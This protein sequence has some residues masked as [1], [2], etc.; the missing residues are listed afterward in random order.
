MYLALRVKSDGRAY[1]VNVQTDGVVLTDIHQHRLFT[2]RPGEW[3]TVLIKW[4]HLVRTNYGFPVEPQTE[5]LRQRVKS[6][7]IGLTD[8]VAGPFDICIERI[9]ATNR[10]EEGDVLDPDGTAHGIGELRNRK[11]ERVKW[12]EGL[13]A[14]GEEGME[15]KDQDQETGDG[16]RVPR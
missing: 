2:K 3:E 13:P 4:N 8:G 7:G 1:F 14:T 11:G 10:I 5:I 9:W 16:E 6:V 15:T 12:S